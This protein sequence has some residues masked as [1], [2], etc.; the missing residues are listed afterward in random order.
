MVYLSMIVTEE[1]K[2]PVKLIIV[3]FYLYEALKNQLEA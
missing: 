2:N 3:D 1:N